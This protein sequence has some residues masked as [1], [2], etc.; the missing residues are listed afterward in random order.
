MK[1]VMYKFNWE[2]IDANVQYY[3]FMGK[4]HMT[5]KNGKSVSTVT[6]FRDEHKTGGLTC[7]LPRL[8]EHRKYFTPVFV[9]V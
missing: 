2:E 1:F 8:Q 5:A 4:L 9:E 3:T 7:R 6:F